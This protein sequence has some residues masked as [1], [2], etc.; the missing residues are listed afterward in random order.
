MP[1]EWQKRRKCQQMID[2]RRQM[3]VLAEQGG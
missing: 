1:A 2:E 3:A